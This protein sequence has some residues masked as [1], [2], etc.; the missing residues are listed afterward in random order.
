MGTNYLDI[1]EYAN[2][3]SLIPFGEENA[4]KRHELVRKTGMY[5]RKNR[6]MI[7]DLRSCVVILNSPKGG[8]FRP[9]KH[10][11]D[12]IEKYIKQE[13]RRAIS[14]FKSVQFAEKYL[15]DVK[16]GVLDV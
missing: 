1:P 10:E 15:E 3:L 7:A 16:R 14:N 11:A 9:T 4:V 12:K 8:Y 2:L 13:K 5:D 6:E